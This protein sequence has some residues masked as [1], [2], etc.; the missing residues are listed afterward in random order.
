[1]LIWTPGAGTPTISLEKK[2]KFLF[3]FS[4]FP[5]SLEMINSGHGP[6]LRPWSSTKT[7]VALPYSRRRQEQMIF[8]PLSCFSS[9]GLC[10]ICYFSL[11]TTCGKPGRN[12]SVAG[13]GHQQINLLSAFDKLIVPKYHLCFSSSLEA[14]RRVYPLKREE[15]EWELG[16]GFTS[17][18][19]GKLIS[20]HQI[21][22]QREE[23]GKSMIPLLGLVSYMHSPNPTKE[24]APNV[25]DPSLRST[26][27]IFL[28]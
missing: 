5:L 14:S 23:Q 11:S 24:L 27:T 18:P 6:V 16:E 7:R 22:F 2:A 26:L 20:P 21:L 10:T 25:N 12:H 3:F 28:H 8:W 13:S 15:K 1:M 9:F 19:F 17:T 4:C